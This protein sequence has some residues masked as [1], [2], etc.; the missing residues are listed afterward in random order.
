VSAVGVVGVVGSDDVPDPDGEPEVVADGP[1][2]EPPSHPTSTVAHSPTMAATAVLARRIGSDLRG[3]NEVATNLDNPRATGHTTD[4]PVDKPATCAT[5]GSNCF[6]PPKLWWAEAHRT[7]GCP[8]FT[9]E[10][11]L[12]RGGWSTGRDDSSTVMIRV[13]EPSVRLMVNVVN[14][15]EDRSISARAWF[16]GP[17][18]L[19][20]NPA[21]PRRHRLGEIGPSTLRC[22]LQGIADEPDERPRSGA[23]DEADDDS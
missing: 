10:A 3:C 4:E 11:T 1:A 8:G 2:A 15:S 18:E 17:K 20:A 12:R 14:G 22:T 6:G 5:P 23:A 7:F 13:A 9:I 21:L 19:S 16:G